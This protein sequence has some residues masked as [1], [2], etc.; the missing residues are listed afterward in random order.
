MK[1]KNVLILISS[2][3]IIFFFALYFSQYTGYYDFSDNSK[4]VLT[5]EAIKKFEADVKAGKKIDASNYLE[6]EKNYSNK[7]SK[8][9]MKISL[10]IEKAFNKGMNA[11]FNEL[12]KTVRG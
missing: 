7:A 6:K 1:G 12:E 11:I 3:T 5:D 8:L 2:I 4:T 10:I 9:G